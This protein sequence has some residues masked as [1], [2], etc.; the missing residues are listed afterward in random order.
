MRSSRGTRGSWRS[1]MLCMIRSE[2]FDFFYKKLKIS[3]HFAYYYN[4]NRDNINADERPGIE[5]YRKYKGVTT[6]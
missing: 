1:S 2:G 5:G 6:P 4:R 3:D